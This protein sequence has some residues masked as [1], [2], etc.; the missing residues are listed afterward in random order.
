MIFIIILCRIVFDGFMYMEPD[1]FYVTRYLDWFCHHKTTT[2]HREN[3]KE[4]IWNVLGHSLDQSIR[5]KYLYVKS[6]MDYYMKD[7]T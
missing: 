6:W 2:D 4:Y 3:A 7:N 1:G 5:E